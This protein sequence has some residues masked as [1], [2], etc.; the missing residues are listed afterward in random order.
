LEPFCTYEKMKFAHMAD[1]HLGGWRDPEL[2]KIN[3]RAF[4]KAVEICISEKVEFIIIGGD[5]F[6]TAM[7]GFDVLDLVSKELNRIKKAG[8]PVYYIAGSHDFSPS[9]KTILKVLEN[10]DLMINVGGVDEGD[11]FK[12]KLIEDKSGAKL[13]GIF[14]K[15]GSLDEEL[16]KRMDGSL[17]GDGYK[18]FLF[19]TGI[20]EFLPDYLA[21]VGGMPLKLLPE[22]FDYYAGAHIHHRSEHEYGDGKV[23][24]PGPLFPCNFAELERFKS[25]G[26]YII[27]DG[28]PRFVDLK[29][30]E[31]ETIKVN[32]EDRKVDEVE[33][34]LKKKIS[35]LNGKDFILLVRV[36]GTLK[37]GKPSD[38]DFKKLFEE[39]HEKGALVARKNTNALSSKE[40]E[41]FEVSTDTVENLEN[42]IIDEHMGQSEMKN[43]KELIERLLKVLD[44]EKMEGE[45][46][47]TY[48]ERV[49]GD[50]DKSIFK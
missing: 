33:S 11:R 24:F 31:V 3:L 7:P 16:Y 35:S 14:G 49:I 39:A 38:I 45:T 25:G 15:K 29:E 5:F 40:Y 30:K 4:E 19:H 48:E 44:T 18:I 32:A 37:E 34:E 46:S 1:L 17:E 6:D 23:I 26:F 9:G 22:G 10:A 13:A 20:T 42:R 27:E 43:E 41:E 21:E 8:I 36:S 50:A 2:E 47:A 28:I 12:I